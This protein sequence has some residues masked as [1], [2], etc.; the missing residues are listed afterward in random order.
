MGATLHH[1]H[2]VHSSSIHIHHLEAQ[3]TPFKT[4]GRSWNAA[5]AHH[6]EACQRLIVL[7]LLSGQSLDSEY[8]LEIVHW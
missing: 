2:F 3:P 7:S 5:E 4:I 1:Q 6:Y 8:L